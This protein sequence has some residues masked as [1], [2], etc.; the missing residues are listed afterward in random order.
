MRQAVGISI[1]SRSRS[2]Q[3][4]CTHGIAENGLF[5]LFLLFGPSSKGSILN[6]SIRVGKV[7]KRHVPK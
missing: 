4:R 5:L 7:T 3:G 6:L 2:E 1:A